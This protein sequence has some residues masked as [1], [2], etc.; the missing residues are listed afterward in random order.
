MPSSNAC[1][2]IEIGAGAIKA[3]KLE[4]DNQRVN[5]LD[6]AYIE[7]AK[8]LSTPGVDANDV[9]RVSLGQLVGQY[10][11][12]KAAIAVSVPGHSAFARFA[13][14]PPVDPKKV[15]DIVKFEAMQQIPFPLEQ[16][17]W[18][19]QTFQSPNSP[20]I[21]VG[22][23]A[24]TK[25]RINERLAML[26]NVGITPDFVT[27]SPLAAFNGLAY[28]LEFSEKSQGTIVVDV[29]TTSTDLIVAEAGR[30]WIRTFPI[31][32]HHFTDALVSTFK[33]GYPKA[34][35]LKKEAEESKH[36]RQVF[37]AMRG[38]FTDLGQDIQRSTGYYTNL[39]KDSDLERLIGIGSTFQLPGLRKFLKQQVG[40]EV[41]RFEE[42]KRANTDSLK[43]E[44]RAKQF[45]ELSLS[46][47]TAYGLALQGLG[48]ASIDANLMPVQMIR[49]TMWRSKVKWFGLAAGLG[50]AASGAMFVRPTID[51][52]Q[53]EGNQRGSVVDN[54]LRIANEHK[55][56]AA[57][58]KVD[59]AAN[60][61]YTAANMLSLME[62]RNIH[63]HLVNDLGE[64]FRDADKKA[65]TW[66]TGDQTPWPLPP[67]EPA[68]SL[69]TFDTV[70]RSP[71]SGG[72]DAGG[73]PD[74]AAAPPP[75]DGSP[76]ASGPA[77][78]GLKIDVT[79]VVEVSRASDSDA[80]AFMIKTVDEWL[81]KNAVRPGVPYK[82]V[83][84]PGQQNYWKRVGPG[85]VQPDAATPDPA[86][87]PPPDGVRGPAGGGRDG[88]RGPKGR[89]A[90]GGGREAPGDAGG[91]NGP[92][93]DGLGLAPLSKLV[94]EAR[95]P[96]PVYTME[97]LWTVEILQP[98]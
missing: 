14:L 88:V 21:E 77:G 53:T 73:V 35:T 33:I 7:H 27:L 90:G 96:G 11:L 47:V 32:G 41:F 55:A 25:E 45:K 48:L 51:Y 52:F 66:K 98:V 68:F 69:K 29:G 72:D 10:D 80:N 74:P 54:A 19:Y 17:E 94:A 62:S 56:D 81:A 58:K 3:I 60:P 42:F 24:I 95:H 87:A 64:I 39:H 43:N 22:I 91:G 75:A 9:L 23:F 26:L 18:D 65:S 67:G 57:E 34:E 12:T 1:W 44:D 63:A 71:R 38:V 85:T 79:L 78:T 15:P 36:A 97:V 82:I 16:V 4:A 70:Y 46:M 59:A 92:A 30:V 89:D 8:V 61:D 40:I 50:V 13:K 37:Q 28:D 49:E 83:K 2:G 93:G 20:D 86:E 84:K 76:A 6:F 5:V 31:G